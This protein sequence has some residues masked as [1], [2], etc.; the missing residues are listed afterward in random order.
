M[1]AAVGAGAGSALLASLRRECAHLRRSRWDLS[2]VTWVPW[3][4][5]AVVMVVFDAGALRRLP[6]AVVDHDRSPA[7]RALV[8]ALDAAPGLAV[9]AMPVALDDA[10]SLLR[11]VDVYAV[12]HVPRDATRQ[13]QRGDAA[14]LFAFY[15]AS[16]LTAGQAAAREIAAVVQARNA[17]EG[18]A[19]AS[20]L[21]GGAGVD[22]V[23]VRVQSTI[24]FNPGRSYEHFLGGLVLPAILQL[25]L[26]LAVVA[27][28]GRELRDGSARAWL[29]A[30]GGR[31][32]P[33][34]AGKL[35]PY[36]ALFTAHLGVVLLWTA[37]LRG[38][39][40]AGSAVLLLCGGFLLF[41]ACAAIGLL[42]VGLTR[43]MGSA[44][45]LTGV[46]LGVAL[47]FSGGTFPTTDGSQFAR[48]WSRLMPFTAY[49]KLQM[50]QVDIGSPWR[51]SLWQIG[52]LALFVLVAGAPGLRLFGRAARDPASWGRR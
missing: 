31:L 23:P 34:V 1:A 26:A 17:A 52:A 9:V 14:T 10:W 48:I 11:R 33:A 12:V 4:L 36:L 24:L 18:A 37:A 29:D 7:S 6:V 19:R 42:L 13:M 21:R 3:L 45:S 25:A 22:A 20:M 39:G 5:L 40:V 2:M 8:R 43:S 15:D 49:V 44:L 35:A 50:Q 27:A 32:L 16:Y 46:T 51:V 47:A 38:N 41:A 30:C 28:L